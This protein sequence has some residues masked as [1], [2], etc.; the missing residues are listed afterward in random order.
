M[1]SMLINTEG[2]KLTRQFQSFVFQDSD[3]LTV[4]T[5]HSLQLTFLEVYQ[6]LEVVIVSCEESKNTREILAAIRGGRLERARLVVVAPKPEQTEFE[7][8]LPGALT[9]IGDRVSVFLSPPEDNSE[10][11]SKLRELDESID[12]A[13]W[14]PS[15]FRKN[16]LWKTYSAAFSRL[17]QAAAGHKVQSSTF[18]GVSLSRSFL[19]LLEKSSRP[20][21]LL[22]GIEGLGGMFWETNELKFKDMRQRFGFF[23][24][25]NRGLDT[26]FN[27]SSAPLRSVSY[28]AIGAA[29]LNVFYSVYVLTVGLTQD[30]ERGW[31]SMSLQVSGMFFLTMLVLATL[32]EFLI[33]MK[34]SLEPQGHS[35]ILKEVSNQ[36]SIEKAS[37]N[38]EATLQVDQ[39]REPE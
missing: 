8:V 32:S 9:A 36:N 21:A 10:L 23:R 26:I 39:F 12:V 18:R 34:R 4:E 24:L 6:D 37:P 19:G 38:V 33:F 16:M 31:T 13:I 20:D 7:R 5:L 11:K 2:V 35:T 22:R 29:V 25:L 1:N 28:L 15:N 30:V 17:Y 27:S 3:S 14:L